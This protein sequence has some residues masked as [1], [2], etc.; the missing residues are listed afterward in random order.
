MD[1]A[2][3]SEVEHSVEN[4]DGNGDFGG[5]GLGGMEAHYRPNDLLEA[6]NL[7]FYQGLRL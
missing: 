6:A 1:G 2:R 5:L 7:A 3:A 4:L